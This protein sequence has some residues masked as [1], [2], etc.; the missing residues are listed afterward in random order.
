M[1]LP[2]T[3]SLQELAVPEE[4]DRWAMEAMENDFFQ[5]IVFNSCKN[6]ENCFSFVLRVGGT[7]AKDYYW[8]TE[9]PRIIISKIARAA[10][11]LNN[12]RVF[13]RSLQVVGESS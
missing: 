7:P 8:G 5:S 4:V 10:E 11:G 3:Q 1:V 9:K 13:S 2:V 6:F 12:E